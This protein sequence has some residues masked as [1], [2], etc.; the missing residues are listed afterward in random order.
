MAKK[1][2]KQRGL[3]DRADDINNDQQTVDRIKRLAEQTGYHPTYI[4][5]WVDVERGKTPEE[6]ANRAA[7]MSRGK[8]DAFTQYSDNSQRQYE[9]GQQMKNSRKNRRHQTDE[10][11][12]GQEFTTEERVAN[13]EYR[14]GEREAG[15]KHENKDRRKTLI[16]NE[17]NIR[18]GDE[19][20]T[21]RERIAR[22]GRQE[23]QA[24][25]NE[26]TTERDEILHGYSKEEIAL[27]N[28]GGPSAFQQQQADSI[29]LQEADP[30][31]DRIGAIR[32]R[33][34]ALYPTENEQEAN[35]RIRDEQQTYYAE[36]FFD[37]TVTPGNPLP[38]GL[39]ME[40]KQ[41]VGAGDE[42]MSYEDFCDYL[43][44]DVSDPGDNADMQQFYTQITGNAPNHDH[45]LW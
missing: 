19:L 18:L 30:S 4:A 32:R 45:W 43:D 3:L 27:R 16:G 44:V 22:E 40:L 25:Q 10:R 29:E 41:V 15:E 13:Q 5:A 12:A 31:P 42:A 1:K 9:T 26:F 23:D 21:D 17:K 38:L 36:K 39:Q 33:N 34:A 8:G 24:N 20:S 35:A 28:D 6:K 37:G 7:Q 11:L 2:K 14:T